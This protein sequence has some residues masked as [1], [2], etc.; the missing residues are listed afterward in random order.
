MS[1]QPAFSHAAQMIPLARE[2]RSRGHAVA[3]AT[4]APFVGRLRALGL[5]ARPFGRSWEER[6]GDELYDQT[7]GRH[8]FF[9]FPQVPDHSS[10]DDLVRLARDT[11]A[12]F[13]VRE[14]SEFT[15]WAVARRLGLP[16]VT[17][18]IIHRLPPPAEARVVELAGRLAALAGIDP[19][20]SPDELLGSAYLDVVPPSFR[21]P[22]EHG[23]TLA[24]PARPSLY[25][26]SEGEPLARSI[27]ELGRERPLIYV[28][29]GTVFNDHPELWRT[30][31]TA[32]SGLDVDA[33]L[34]TG[35][36]VDPTGLGATP[37]VRIERYLPQSQVLPRCA[38]V[39]CHAGF[40]TLIGSFS[41]GLPA[42]CIPLDAD[43]P[44]NARCAAEAGAGIN[45]ANTPARDLRGPSADPDTLDPDELASAL[46]RLLEEP[47]FAYAA[48]RLAT[49]IQAM[50]GPEKTADLLEQLAGSRPTAILRA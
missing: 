36:N 6:P 19:P 1:T 10:V 42:L 32:L 49:E 22:W 16:L 4:S 26:G 45:A 18:A 50:P 7:I 2:L 11:G 34:T 47:A 13:V 48:Q 29:F 23:V 46:V 38:A 31:L 30:V 17:Q 27:D 40:N 9:G 25:D 33:L 41:H 14:Y 15:G 5:D 44:V 12:Q 28:T 39:I 37:N 24:R 20:D 3:V 8:S 21:C 43:Q 35:P